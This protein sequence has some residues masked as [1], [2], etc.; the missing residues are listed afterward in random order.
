MEGSGVLETTILVA[1]IKDIPAT[2]VNEELITTDITTRMIKMK[3]I[4][5][6]RTEMIAPARTEMIAP[7]RTEM[8]APVR[9]EM[10]APVDIIKDIRDAP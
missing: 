6:A 7:A 8:I 4:A 3:M 10:I 2:T 1:T 5:P 9:T